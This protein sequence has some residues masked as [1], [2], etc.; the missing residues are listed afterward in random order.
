MSDKTYNGWSNYETWA[1]KLWIDNEQSSQEYWLERAKEETT[2]YELARALK[3]E[4]N[5][6]NP[7]QT[8]S[9]YSDLMSAAL[10]GVDWLEIANSLLEDLSELEYIEPIDEV[11]EQ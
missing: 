2:P 6:A 4:F 10:S 3:D 5:E 9:V 11:E 7:I 1:V 8:A